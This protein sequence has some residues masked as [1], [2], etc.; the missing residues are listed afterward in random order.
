[1]RQ[2]RARVILTTIHRYF[3]ITSH[4]FSHLSEVGLLDRESGGGGD[5][6]GENSELHGE[7]VKVDID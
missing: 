5:K 1:M 4:R 6:G 2:A 3:P 7:I